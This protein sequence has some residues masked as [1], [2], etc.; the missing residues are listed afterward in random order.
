MVDEN[1]EPLYPTNYN[2]PSFSSHPRKMVLD[3]ELDLFYET[4]IVCGC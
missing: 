4:P 3:Y 1:G 2:M